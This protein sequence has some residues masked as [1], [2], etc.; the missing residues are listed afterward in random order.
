M[1]TGMKILI[2]SFECWRDDTNG[3][4]VL[5]NLFA[6]MDGAEFAQ[7]YCKGGLPQNQICK[8]YYRMNDRMAL[9]ALLHFQR[10]VGEELRYSDWPAEPTP[11]GK[12]KRFYDF[13]RRHDWPIFHVIRELLWAAAPWRSA[14]LLRFVQEFAPDI[15]FAPCYGSLFMQRL[16]RWV[17][18]Q[19][20]APVVS[21]ISDDN[22]SLRQLR[23]SPA[24]WVHRFLLRSSIRKTARQYRWMYTMTQQQAEE[25]GPQL[26]TQMRILRKAA[27][28]FPRR[29]HT[30]PDQAVRLIYAGGT[31]LG[32]DAVLLRVA[33]AVRALNA[34]AHPCRLDIYTNSEIPKKWQ[35]ELN[36]GTNSTIH[37][38]IPMKDLERRYAESDIALHVES[39][40]KK[41]AL[42]TRLSFSTKIVDCLASGCA[43]LAVCPHENAGWQYL[44]AENAALCV[45]SPEDVEPA[46]QKLVTDAAYRQ[47]LA[48]AARGCLEL[49]HRPE[50]IQKQFFTQICK[51]VQDG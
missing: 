31:Y 24:F 37:A 6:G 3:G 25:L 32:R 42:L 43:V 13:F 44:K 34:K 7:I 50:D 38:A 48:R 10:F 41:D 36:D 22:Y 23:F 17:F 51:I 45:D 15:I 40:Q 19:A 49:H 11:A 1:F 20:S 33:R 5:S 8:R 27:A 18:R 26:H 47:K 30:K 12:E 9:H 35:S 29:E 14:K 39:F 4:N 21:Y 28:P 46:V 16:D 2:I